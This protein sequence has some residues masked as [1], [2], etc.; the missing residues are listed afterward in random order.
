MNTYKGK[1]KILMSALAA[2]VA[3]TPAAFAFTSGST[4]ADGAFNPTVDQT[5][6]LPPSGIFNFTSV[7][8]PTGVTVRFKKNTTNTP[9]TILATGNVTIAGTIDVAG[10]SSPYAGAASDGNLGDDGIPGKG[11]PGGYD[12]GAGGNVPNGRGGN[13]LGPGGGGGG[14]YVSQYGPTEG[15]GGGYA[16]GGGYGNAYYNGYR[17]N[18]GNTG[19]GGPSY[20]SSLLLPLVGGSGGGGGAGGP[21][22][23]GAGGGGGGGAIL[24]AASGT[25][26]ISGT[27]Y[28]HG[29]HSGLSAGQGM[30]AVGGGGSGGAIRIVATTIAGNG[31]IY[32]YRGYAGYRNGD[33]NSHYVYNDNQVYGAASVG[34]VR[35]EA[36]TITRTAASNPAHSFGAPG[37]VFVAGL[38]TLRIAS[39]AGVATP[40]EPTG[41]ADIT[42][43]T[44]TANPVTVVLDT[45]GVPVGNTVKLTVTPA[46]GNP[47]SVVSP[48][49]TGTT[50][51]AT[52]SVQVSL[53]GGPSVLQAT[54]T[55]TIVASLGDLLGN[56]YANGERVEKIE[57]A[58]TMGA[59][60]STATLITVSGKR[61]PMIA[62]IPSL[63]VKG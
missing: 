34:R 25:V 50:D 57:V 59:A 42:L 37:P 22:F 63:G 32:A 54:T 29:G 17:E 52:A 5:L 1:T 2:L 30:G 33:A 39:V 44:T 38:P 24:I 26:N 40:A 46:N 27:I 8:I 9:V 51:S 47:V 15:G 14:V 35:L 7:N 3:V 31:T 60:G 18:Y 10:T 58:A 23:R 20:G 16:G 56:Q 41:N 43:P 4:G 62:P 13:G 36:E 53:P 45:V 28:A 12:G 6:D 21:S 11:G 19:V 49:L 61:Y 55:Y 48:A